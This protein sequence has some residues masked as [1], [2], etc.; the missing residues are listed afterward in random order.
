[1]ASSATAIK[2]PPIP[3]A[4]APDPTGFGEDA[5]VTFC[6]ISWAKEERQDRRINMVVHMVQYNIMCIKYFICCIGFS[7][8]VSYQQSAFSLKKIQTFIIKVYWSLNI[9][10]QIKCI[11][12]KLKLFNI[13]KE[14]HADGCALKAIYQ[15]SAFL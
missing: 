12:L 5:I 1:V 2:A 8:A 13:N 15:F 6:G 4:R 14:L 3:I 7:L 9:F 10:P 11:L